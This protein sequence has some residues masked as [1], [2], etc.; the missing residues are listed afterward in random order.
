MLVVSFQQLVD[1]VH[2]TSVYF[3]RI[4]MYGGC[5]GN[6][7]KLYHIQFLSGSSYYSS[8]S[9]TVTGK[10]ALINRIVIIKNK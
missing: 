1:P 4:N 5:E 8:G 9:S 6:F 3:V 7:S 10:I 2:Q